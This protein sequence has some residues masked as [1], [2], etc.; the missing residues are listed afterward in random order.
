MNGVPQ[1]KARVD[2]V[3]L[4]RGLIMAIMMLDHT[5]DF[6]H[7]AAFNFDPTNVARTYPI[8]F[9]TRWITHFCAPLFVFLAG[10]GA[11]FQGMRGKSKGELSRFLVARGLWFIFVELAILRVVI[12]FTTDYGALLAFL[13]VIWVIGW[14]L[15]FLAAV[16]H[17]P[18]QWILFIGL[19]MIALHNTLDGVKVTTWTGPGSAVPGFAASLWQI[20]HQSGVIFPLGY[21][22]HAVLV[23]YPL[24]P[25]IGVMCAGY[26]FGSIYELPERDRRRRL[27]QLGA[28]VTLGFVVLRA[29]NVYGDPIP[30]SPQ[31]TATKTVMSF[32][33]VS[34]YPPSLLY[35]M[36]TLG[37]AML[38]LAAFERHA[39]IPLGRVLTT[40]G[41]VPFF[42]YVLQW[43]TAH[44]FAIIASRLAG[45]PTD[46]LFSNI[47]F[48]AVPPPGAGFNLGV[49]Y[50]FWILGLMLLYPLCRWFAG[51]KSRRR[52]WWLS[53]L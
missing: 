43:L 6:I 10:T 38:L 40:F 11:Y 12:F 17:L 22:G 21:P 50:A 47:G 32:L 7:S 51:V 44:T 1:R 15:I 28:A 2:S 53:Y 27:L 37:P 36:M 52:D 8:L 42:F 29:L 39:R 41:R 3:D 30:W 24:I 20:L 19:A 48:S 14:S 35:L 33:A 9:F 18:R 31:P 26:V 46:Y 34:K 13:Q 4:L 45:K 49:V 5:R 16:I 23:L 25:W